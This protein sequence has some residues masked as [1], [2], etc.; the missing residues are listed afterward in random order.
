M[1]SFVISN[2]KFNKDVV[3]VEVV[4]REQMHRRKLEDMEQEITC[5]TNRLLCETTFFKALGKI[6]PNIWL[7]FMLA[8]QGVNYIDFD[9]AGC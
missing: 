9:I 4:R 5:F 7:I 6:A 3:S 1:G 2:Q 8:C